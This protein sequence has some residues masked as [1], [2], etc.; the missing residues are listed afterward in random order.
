MDSRLEIPALP[1]AHAR[2]LQMLGGDHTDIGDL[3]EVVE[4]DAGLSGSVLRAANSAASAPVSR[5]TSIHLAIP[6]IGLR[7]TREIV[8]GTVANRAFQRL[9]DAGMDVDETWSHQLMVA[10]LCH[11]EARRRALNVETAEAA[12]ILGLL[13]D[14]GRLSM[15]SQEP[16]RYRRVMQLVERDMEPLQAERMIFGFTHAEWG[17]EVAR[18]WEMDLRLA[19]AVEGHHDQVQDDR[20]VLTQTLSAARRITQSLGVG[21]GLHRRPAEVPAR[22]AD[23]DATLA[24]LGG[25]EGLFAQLEWYRGAMTLVAA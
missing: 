22:T 16:L 7:V 9:V 25:A 20:A 2:A 11:G 13:H 5:I 4:G 10:M 18:A 1:A 6:R 17:G 19:E 24:L 8:L 21:D 23:D 3:A 14:V 15:A 12:Y